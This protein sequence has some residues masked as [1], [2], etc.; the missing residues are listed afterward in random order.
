MPLADDVLQATVAELSRRPGH[1]KVRTLVHKLLT[2]ALGARSEQITYEHRLPE[3]KGRIDALLG[4]TVI[5]IKSDLRREEADAEEQL[6]RYLPEREA[7]TGH[8]Y[9]GLATDGAKLVAYEMRDGRLVRLTEHESRA[10]DP[11]QL[12][13][14]LE[15]VVAV[16]DRL[17]ADALN[18]VNELGRQSAAFARTLGL[19]AK[20]WAAVADHPEATLKRQLWARHLGFVYGK[21]VEDDE[22]WLQHTYLVTVAKAIAAGAMGFG[23]LTPRDLLSGQPFRQ[24]GVHGAVE[25]DFFA[26]VLDAPGG[27]DIVDKLLA[28]AARF[29]L[30]TV[31]VD[32]LKVL[33]E[34]LIDPKQRHDL[35]EYYTPDWLAR[36]VVRRAV[37]RPADDSVLDPACG[38]GSFL[39]HALRLK[40]EALEKAGTDVKDIAERCCA[41]VT[42][43]DVHPVAVIFARVT[44]LL[45]LGA[46]LLKRE[47]DLSVPVYL[48]DALQWNVRRDAAEQDLVV[49]VP[50]DPREGRKGAPLLRFPLGLCADP[51][52]FDRVVTVLHQASEAGRTPE[53][54]ARSLHGLR[55]D[56]DHVEALKATYVTYDRLRRA[57]RDHIWT[58]FARNLSRPVALSDSARADVV[59]GNPPWLSY[60]YMA[61]P[62]QARFR[63]TARALGVWVASD[64]ARLVT[65]TDLS[66]LFF[67]RSAQLYARRATPERGGGRV[68]MVMPLAAL[69]RGQFRAFRGGAWH[70]VT[71]RFEEA[72]VLD[73][74]EIEPL[75]R[76]PTCVLYAQRTHA[77]ATR[78]PSRVTAFVGR[79]PFKD[80]PEELADRHVTVFDAPAPSE[81]SF[82]AGSPYR[83]R[84]RQGAT[85]VPRM[86][87]L[88]ERAEAGRL[89][90]SAAAPL[91]RSRR[92]T[93]EKKPWIDLEPLQSAVEA[94]FLRPVYLGE[95]IAPFRVLRAFEGIIPV[96][97]GGDVL[98][99]RQ[100]G[101][102]G[103][104]R[105][106]AWMRQ[107]EALW[108]KHSAGA[109]TLTERW[110][111]HNGLS[112]QFPINRLRIAFSAS[113][114]LPTAVV[115][116]DGNGVVEHAIYWAAIATE[117]EGQ[118]LAAIL[119]SENGRARV[120]HMQSRGEQ[121]A[122]HFDKLMFTLPIPRFDPRAALHAELA[123]AGQAAEGAAAAVPIPENTPFVRARSTIRE[124]LR[125]DG[126]AARIDVLVEALLGPDPDRP[127]APSVP[128]LRPRERARWLAEAEAA[129]RR[130]KDD[131][132]EQVL[133]DEIEAIQA[134]NVGTL[135]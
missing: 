93:L 31:E 59:V 43:I 30:G 97:P 88:V 126:I 95:S 125:D 55:V 68:A 16:Q 67:A 27:T 111:F 124:A 25:E 19:L 15:G 18:I 87:C 110:N 106:A 98:D 22:L 91:V 71:V 105:L 121:G 4:R 66:G 120:E 33:Y 52:L 99:G 112:T 49:E 39:F 8:R 70:G 115:L 116:R 131:P 73:N 35:G 74:Q 47:G 14:W 44:Y 48:G 92:S 21:A 107:S 69:T 108:N 104:T 80:A 3:V 122:R 20:A 37:E 65:Q 50:P 76:V 60:R 84:F 86:L 56:P 117:E 82:A 81:V 2:D 12:T 46:A 53:A 132:R 63:D 129:S 7:A 57:G 113:G 5:E 29:D 62:M 134:E 123:A 13:A 83:E 75:F 40:R 114:T 41:S 6:A 89:G 28:H 109:R 130:L 36:K 127:V 61:Q 90:S 64:E 135:E 24:A 11:R 17:P 78:T 133:L 101:D 128:R 119:N 58:F 32:L 42:G 1:E 72:W 118:Y 77:L 45:A 38:S 102:R 9:V 10:A 54:F 79:L 96:L 51:V 85:L 94:E 34:S 103:F 23:R 26:W 100:A